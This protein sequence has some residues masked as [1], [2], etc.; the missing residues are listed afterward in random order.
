MTFKNL[1]QGALRYTVGA[2]AKKLEDMHHNLE[3]KLFADS[4]PRVRA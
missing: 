4:S 3:H 1:C 2:Y